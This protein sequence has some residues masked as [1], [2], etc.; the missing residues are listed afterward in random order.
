[1]A[2]KKIHL[3][4][5]LMLVMS[6]CLTACGGS[7]NQP[8][9][10]S[11][12]AATANPSPQTSQPEEATATTWKPERA[13]TINCWS[14]AGGGTDMAC[15]AMAAALQDYFGVPFNVA[16]MAGGSGGIAANYVWSQPHDGYNLVGASEALHSMA[17][18]GAFDKDNSAWDVHILCTMFGC[19]SVRSD[20]P[21]NT[22]DE[23][24]EASKTTEF[25]AGASQKGS[26]WAVNLQ[27][28]LDM[29]DTSMNL[30]PYDGSNASV[31]ALLS[32]EIDVV[33]CGLSEQL[34][35]IKA[36]EIRP[37][38]MIDDTGRAIEGYGDIPA[39]NEYYPE[40]STTNMARQWS[41]LLLPSDCPQEVLDA[42]NA[43]FEYI[44]ND[45]GVL[46]FVD[47]MDYML[48]GY[49][50]ESADVFMK[51][52]DSIFAWTLYDAGIATKN[53]EDFGI[54]RP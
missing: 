10:Q 44:I 43:A 45:R 52:S 1:M 36:G 34:D 22:L 32:N 49:Q 18:Q 21:Y 5:A 2:N 53:P 26:V 47:D 13:V 24:L 30:L 31:V 17:V 33:L 20:S 40:F 15:R 25:K 6:L 38:A 4:I 35:Y 51:T 3:L 16:N 46:Q 19:I 29:A 8:Q 14:A 42:Y 39:L 27:Q 37:L 11:Q 54:A 7:S 48:L 41:G 50:G 12:P 9:S 28:L 23:L